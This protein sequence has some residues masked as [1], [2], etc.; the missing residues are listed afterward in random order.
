MGV[1]GIFFDFFPRVVTEK[2]DHEVWGSS[3]GSFFV[4]TATLTYFMRYFT[5]SPGAVRRSYGL[6]G[7]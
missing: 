1:L 6:M 3:G 5:R 7:E 4:S 2:V